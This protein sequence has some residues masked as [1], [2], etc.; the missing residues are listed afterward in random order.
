MVATPLLQSLNL[1][2]DDSFP[3]T[4]SLSL[5]PGLPLSLALVQLILFS[6]LLAKNYFGNLLTQHGVLWSKNVQSS[7]PIHYVSYLRNYATTK[8]KIIVIVVTDFFFSV[9]VGGV[10]VALQQTMVVIYDLNE[11]GVRGVKWRFR[12]FVHSS[13][14][15]CDSLSM[16]DVGIFT[17][18]AYI[19]FQELG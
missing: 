12:S 8:C 3:L 2:K 11:G 6:V 17:F 4:T 5:Q 15:F 7:V 19:I 10:R 1:D 18:C 9:P 16:R 14:P 13:F